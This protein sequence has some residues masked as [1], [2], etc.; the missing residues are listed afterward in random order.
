[1]TGALRRQGMFARL[2]QRLEEAGFAAMVSEPVLVSSFVIIDLRDVSGGSWFG[3]AWQMRV[4]VV[5]AVA[6]EGPYEADTGWGPA[7]VVELA[8]RVMPPVEPGQLADR[9][10]QMA[11]WAGEQLE[12]VRS[13]PEVRV[14][15]QMAQAQWYLKKA[16]GCRQGVADRLWRDRLLDGVP[17]QVRAEMAEWVHGFGS[18]P[19]MLRAE[20]TAHERAVYPLVRGRCGEAAA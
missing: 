3:Y 14:R 11:A 18:E 6:P 16:A 12:Q 15:Q 4:A 2:R 17:A 19:L 5:T 8:T 1:M 13:S 20:R 10:P 7:G 9:V